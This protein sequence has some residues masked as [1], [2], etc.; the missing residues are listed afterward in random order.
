[1]T[2]DRSGIGEVGTLYVVA[3]PIGHLSDLGVRAAEVLR[4]VDVV[5]A[6]DT[7]TSRVLLER[8]G[9]HARLM[10]AHR[11]NEREAGAKIVALLAEGRRVALVS[12]AGTPAVS[13]PGAR[14]V[15]MALHAGH[16]VVPIPGPSA[17]IAL[18]SAC[19]LVEGPFHFEGFLPARAKQRD[20]RLATLARMP[21]AFVLF[22]APHRIARTLPA[23]AAACGAAR[24]I[25]IG[26]EL[27]KRFE[28]VHLCRA[29]EAS[30]W[31][32]AD[33]N[34]ERGE[35]VL[36]V[37]AP[38]HE[39]LWGDDAITGERSVRTSAAEADAAAQ[40]AGSATAAAGVNV[41]AQ[42]LLAALLDELPLSRAVKVAAR[43]TGLPHR[44]LYR[45]ALALEAAGR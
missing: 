18:L 42:P 19:G 7:R 4:E 6:E 34:R 16:R 36:V 35:Y 24:W 44:T 26:R 15:A 14:I 13:D 41:D 5:A 29:G 1:M 9:S 2:E 33:P 25:A 40:R 20:A 22:E 27:T 32:Q 11:H 31:L 10:A 38:D 8:I 45:L 39:P 43:A 17:P 12:D 37:A 23:I 28:E 3:T 30:A 21:H